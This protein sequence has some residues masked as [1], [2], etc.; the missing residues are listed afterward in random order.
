MLEGLSHGGEYA[1]E[2]SHCWGWTHD[3]FLFAHLS[4]I[5]S[6]II[7]LWTLSMTF[8]W[9]PNQLGP[10][11]LSFVTVIWTYHL[12]TGLGLRSCVCGSLCT[13][14][15]QSPLHSPGTARG[16]LGGSGEGSR[17]C[18][19]TAPWRRQGSQVLP[20]WGGGAPD[21]QP[22]DAAAA[23]RGCRSPAWTPATKQRPSVPLR[24]PGHRALEDTGP[25]VQGWG[26]L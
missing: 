22:S 9:L 16:P 5:L 12:G 25:E 10:C 6:L 18:R 3:T 8:P 26:G 11:N 23:T 7:S 19:V 24:P 2:N 20:W 21:A 14:C 4:I 17:A 13:R 1:R 15:R